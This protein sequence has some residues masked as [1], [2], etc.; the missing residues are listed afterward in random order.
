[1]GYTAPHTFSAGTPLLS[2]EVEGNLKALKEYLNGGVAAGT[3]DLEAVKWC[4][5]KHITRP[6]YETIP[7]TMSFVTGFQGGKSRTYPAELFPAV[8][9]YTTQRMNSATL[10]LDDAPL[11]YIQNTSVHLKIP[12]VCRAILIQYSVSPVSP[13]NN[14]PAPLGGNLRSQYEI[15]F[16]Q[17]NPPTLPLTGDSKSRSYTWKESPMMAG[18]YSWKRFAGQ[19]FFLQEGLQAGDYYIGLIGKSDLPYT[20]FRHWTIS[21]EVWRD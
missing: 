19:G 2:A 9:R 1:M 7:S 17:L 5:T 6:V 4:E 14:V 12:T 16:A 11:N 15:Y 3:A 10:S 13:Y 21:V 20:I 18:L 8:S